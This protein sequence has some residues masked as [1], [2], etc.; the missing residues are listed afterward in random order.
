MPEW[1]KLIGDLK[2]DS[3]HDVEEQTFHYC[4]SMV[5]KSR[6]VYP[7]FAMPCTLEKFCLMLCILGGEGKL[8]Y[9][10]IVE[11][12]VAKV[13][14]FFAIVKRGV[15]SL[16]PGSFENNPISHVVIF[17]FFCKKIL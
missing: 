13:G 16:D 12:E 17:L 14:T 4:L 7:M 2:K 9:I 10:K 6:K 11:A 1:S 3:I 15:E 5:N 8:A